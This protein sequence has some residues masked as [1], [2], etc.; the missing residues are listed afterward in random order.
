MNAPRAKLTLK[1]YETNQEVRWCPG[2]GDYA[3]LKTIQKLL[4]EP[5]C[6]ERTRFLYPALDVHP[7]FRTTSKRMGSIRFTVAHRQLQRELS[8]LIQNWMYG[9][10]PVTATVSASEVTTWFMFCVRMWI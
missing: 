5:A 6:P 4:P 1:D 8:L 3:I 10:L 2:C 9:L 7:G